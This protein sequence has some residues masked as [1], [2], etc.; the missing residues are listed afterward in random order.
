MAATPAG[1]ASLT[2]AC[3]DALALLDFLDSSP[4]KKRRPVTKA[5]LQQCDSLV[6]AR[7]F[8]AGALLGFS[9]GKAF[10]IRK[11]GKL[12]EVQLQVCA[13]STGGHQRRALPPLVAR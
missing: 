3:N 7:S 11:L 5:L 1:A 2:E 6:F 8:R 9:S 13:L 10:M 4:S 12:A